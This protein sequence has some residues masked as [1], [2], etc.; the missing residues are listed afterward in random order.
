MTIRQCEQVNEA[1][2]KSML[3]TH[4]RVPDRQD[5]D[6]H[7]GGELPDVAR[8]HDPQREQ[9]QVRLLLREAAGVL[10]LER[11]HV[12]APACLIDDQQGESLQEPGRGRVP[13]DAHEQTPGRGPGVGCA[14]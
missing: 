7:E 1:C 11:A 3:K 8:A 5:V 13:Q 6:G 12:D 14:P 9:H 2:T 10:G 4:V